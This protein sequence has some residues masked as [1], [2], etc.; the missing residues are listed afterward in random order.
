VR[1]RPP[2][3]YPDA[4]VPGHERWWDGGSWSHVTRP[5]PGATA[6]RSG[7]AG[8]GSQGAPGGLP[9]GGY[10]GPG[11]P[12]RIT[13]IQ[14]VTTPD[15]LPLAGPGRRLLARIL[16]GFVVSVAMVVVGFPLLSDMADVLV[17]FVDHAQQAAAS[18][19]QVD[20]LDLYTDQRYVAA[21]AR[22]GAIQL[23][24]SAIYHTSLIA[25]RGATLGKLAVGVRVR[26]W[27]ADRRPTWGQAALRWAGRD[28]GSLI[29]MIGPLYFVLDSLWLLRDERRQCLHDKLPSTCAVRS[30]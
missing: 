20:L 5:A 10:P 7:S 6:E 19:A 23:A 15:G 1:E 2:G 22:L 8:G 9:P 25:L 26:P 16:D 3:W 4:S 13:R 30:R 18:G 12:D 11:Y 24:L 29:P 17:R 27:D 21:L 28:V 14:A